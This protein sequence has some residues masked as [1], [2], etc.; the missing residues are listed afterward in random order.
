MD[1]LAGIQAFV[2][3]AESHSFIEAARELGLSPSAVSKLVSRTEEHVGAKLFHRSTRSISLTA[4]GSL[5]LARCRSILEEL[6]EARQEL[7]TASAVPRG[8][9]RVSCPNLASIFLPMIDG[10]TRAFPEIQLEIDF[11][12]RL[13][14]VID[15]GFDVVVRTGQVADSRLSAR[16]LTHYAMRL[17]GSP[18]YF[19]ARAIPASPGDLNGHDC[20]QYRF[21]SS[22]KM[23]VWP[24]DQDQSYELRLQE[25]LI[26]NSTEG[27]LALAL[28]GKGI[29]CLPDFVVLPHLEAG[30]LISV[31][32]KHLD[33]SGSFQLLW[34]TSRHRN[35]K[36]RAFVDYCSAHLFA[37]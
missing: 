34:P 16:F 37:S 32:E 18:G 8:K 6:D 31:L 35:P 30:S 1:V 11:T 19:A 15:E 2:Q 10:F 14:N 29:A 21:P 13:V 3:V 7:A 27:R 25:T 36:L 26:C 24:L 12:D 17:V 33:W 20:I 9:L 28:M 23:E 4:E 5:F 22:G